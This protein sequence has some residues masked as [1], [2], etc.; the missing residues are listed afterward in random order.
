M[1]FPFMVMA[2]FQVGGTREGCNAYRCCLRTLVTVLT[3]TEFE[4]M[5]ES[6]GS[7]RGH[8]IPSA[9]SL[10]N[11]RLQRVCCTQVARELDANTLSNDYPHRTASMASQSVVDSR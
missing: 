6:S 1:K 8:I 11:L 2:A 5:R 4:F 3:S 7:R 9:K 10:L